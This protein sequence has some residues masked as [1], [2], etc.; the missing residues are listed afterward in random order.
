MG[1]AER[2]TCTDIAIRLT[3]T[4]VPSLTLHFRHAGYATAIA[5]GHSHQV[6]RE[7]GKAVEVLV[8]FF[9]ADT[10][11]RPRVMLSAAEDFSEW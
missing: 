10:V 5:A 11:S 8:R 7:V 6:H 2:V 9:L 4:T 1:V 3:V